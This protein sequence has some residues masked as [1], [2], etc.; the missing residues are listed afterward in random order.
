MKV[1]GS[2]AGEYLSLGFWVN[3][4]RNV[5]D[6]VCFTPMLAVEA[7]QM[8]FC[9]SMLSMHVETVH[10]CQKREQY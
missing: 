2:R 5:Q 3:V 6:A 8:W 4:P 7:L 9:C 1:S 10:Q